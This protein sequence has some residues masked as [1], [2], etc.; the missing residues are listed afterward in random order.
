MRYFKPFLSEA[1]DYKQLDL[2]GNL[3]DNAQVTDLGGQTSTFVTT[4]VGTLTLETSFVTRNGQ[5]GTRQ[6][7]NKEQALALRDFLNKF[8]PKE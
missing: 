3:H 5:Q 4:P 6:V 7:F 1:S 2:C 8:L